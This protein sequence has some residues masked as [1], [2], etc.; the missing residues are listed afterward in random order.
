MEN[1]TQNP[2]TTQSAPRPKTNRGKALAS[3]DA[4]RHSA[5]AGLTLIDGESKESFLTFASGL[6]ETLQPSDEYESC[7]V[8]NMLT[9]MWR[10]TRAMAM[11]AAAVSGLVRKA[12]GLATYAPS[13]PGTA[14]GHTSVHQL[15]FQGI[16]ASPAE[17]QALDLL[18]RY[19]SRHTRAFERAAKCLHAYRRL[20]HQIPDACPPQPV[21]DDTAAEN[22][23]TENLPNDPEP[24]P[25]PAPASAPE[26]VPHPNP[27][28]NPEPDTKN[29]P[30]EPEPPVA[31]ATQNAPK[32]PENPVVGRVGNPRGC[33][34]QPH[35]T[36]R[37]RIQCPA[38]QG[39]AISR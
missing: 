34:R 28:A 39:N 15:A 14:P 2:E 20:R 16:V 17:Q 35:A 36:E 4:A 6:Y 38:R 9:F 32:E 29:Q 10:R 25:A 23:P 19:E 33:R 30:K 21:D 1:L 7:L 5:L 11:E 8:D 22:L 31:R 24:A 18:H 13:Q 27:H 3:E 37:A 12:R 26:P